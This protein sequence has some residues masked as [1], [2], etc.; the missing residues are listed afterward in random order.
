M[1]RQAGVSKKDGKTILTAPKSKGLGKA[2]EESDDE[3]KFGSKDYRNKTRGWTR[4]AEDLPSEEL[5]PLITAAMSAA[6]ATARRLPIL[7]V[8]DSD[9]D[10]RAMLAG[11]AWRKHGQE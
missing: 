2:A 10:P 6:G 11:R 7:K 8:Y 9:E 1:N 3:G 5:Q 4:C